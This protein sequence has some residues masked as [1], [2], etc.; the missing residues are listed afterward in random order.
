[1]FLSVYALWSRGIFFDRMK[2]V[3]FFGRIANYSSSEELRKSIKATTEK[4]LL[5]QA[6]ANLYILSRNTRFKHRIVD[7]AA[8]V[9]SLS[10]LGTVLAAV[11]IVTG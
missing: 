9:S 4:E 6:T 7:I 2:A 1:M 11:L 3:N 5:S 10:L 8:A